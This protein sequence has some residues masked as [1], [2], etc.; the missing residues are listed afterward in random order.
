MYIEITIEKKGIK[1]LFFGNN[2]SIITLEKE[3]KNGSKRGQ[4]NGIF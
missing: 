2:Y 1:S 3:E 4:K